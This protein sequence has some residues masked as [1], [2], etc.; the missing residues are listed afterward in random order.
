MPDPHTFY[1]Y[2]SEA[3]MRNSPMYL[4]YSAIRSPHLKI[5]FAHQAVMACP[6]CYTI[7]PTELRE[8]NWA[9][10]DD[11]IDVMS[12]QS[13]AYAP[14]DSVYWLLPAM[15]PLMARHFMHFFI[16][17]VSYAFADRSRTD[18]LAYFVGMVYWKP[19]TDQSALP[20]LPYDTARTWVLNSPEIGYAMLSL[21][22]K[23]A[24]PDLIDILRQHPAKRSYAHTI[25]PALL[26][27]EM[28][29]RIITAYPDAYETLP[30][31]HR[32]P[33]LVPILFARATNN[34]WVSH[35]PASAWCPEYV[36]ELLAR[37]ITNYR[38]LPSRVKEQYPDATTA[39]VHRDPSKYMYH[40]P[41]R[42][43]QDRWDLAEFVVRQVPQAYHTVPP[44]MRNVDPDTSLEDKMRVMEL[45]RVATRKTLDATALTPVTRTRW[46]TEES[47]WHFSSPAR[48]R[49]VA[50]NMTPLTRRTFLR[51]LYDAGEYEHLRQID[52]LHDTRDAI[53]TKATIAQQALARVPG[54]PTDLI[55]DVI[56]A[57]AGP[58]SLADQHAQWATDDFLRPMWTQINALLYTIRLDLMLQ[59]VGILRRIREYV[60]DALRFFCDLH[61]AWTIRA[62]DDPQP[63]PLNR[64]TPA[65]IQSTQVV[66]RQLWEAFGIV[67][68]VAE[69]YMAH[70][71]TH[72]PQRRFF[73]EQMPALLLEHGFPMPTDLQLP[74]LA[75]Q[76]LDKP[77]AAN[78]IDET[79]FCDDAHEVFP[80]IV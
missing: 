11:A 78:R 76:Y 24:Y 48:W 30:R 69:R 73:T 5:F 13:T 47:P 66:A 6:A 27:R 74:P 54:L 8:N 2:D 43:K 72:M 3:Q 7:T 79:M 38:W 20:L 9:L 63:V 59:D 55:T 52:E 12:E 10:V 36:Q 29:T 16:H 44:E 22:T 68:A 32:Y 46:V 58:L 57:H 64:L 62:T 35:V 53:A 49:N 4:T 40:I 56:G 61:Y 75:A 77:P 25:P 17:P 50:Q 65:Q 18:Q 23:L 21:D 14:P 34:A 45:A 42:A 26:D 60:E 39:Y 51:H 19:T 80:K 71:F 41:S 15:P 1:G 67:Q 33:E 37:D 70:F 31:D 28:C